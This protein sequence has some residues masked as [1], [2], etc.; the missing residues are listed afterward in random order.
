MIL[1]PGGIHGNDHVQSF[2]V[3]LGGVH[4]RFI[5]GEPRP[6]VPADQPVSGK[7][8]DEHDGKNQDHMKIYF[9]FFSI[10]KINHAFLIDGNIWDAGENMSVK[11]CPACAACSGTLLVC[12]GVWHSA[13]GLLRKIGNFTYKIVLNQGET[14]MDGGFRH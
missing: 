11:I 3:K 6:L 2:Y 14:A 7:A 12:G 5:V 9:C 4:V 10:H 8:C 13:S 1:E